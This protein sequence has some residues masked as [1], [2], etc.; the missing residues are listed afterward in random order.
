[1]YNKI[2]LLYVHIVYRVLNRFSVITA[3]SLDGRPH[4]L[5][6]GRCYRP[7]RFVGPVATCDGETVQYVSAEYIDHVAGEDEPKSTAGSVRFAP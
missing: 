2:L 6:L 3:L 5:I 4:S 1:M 7:G